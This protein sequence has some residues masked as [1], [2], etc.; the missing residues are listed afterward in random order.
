MAP[1][2]P[3]AGSSIIGNS[4]NAGTGGSGNSVESQGNSGNTGNQSPG[5]RSIAPEEVRDHEYL[6]KFENAGDF[7]KD[8]IEARSKMPGSKPK[9]GATAE[10]LIAWRK[11]RGLPEKPEG[12][13]VSTK[14]GDGTELG[15]DVRKDLQKFFHDNDMTSDTAKAVTTKLIGMIGKGSA[16]YP[17]LVDGIKIEVR[18][19]L[20]G[21]AD[22]ERDAGVLALNKEWGDKYK[23]NV[24][25]ADR[26]L[27]KL[28]SKEDITEMVKD[29]I[30]RNPKLI[31]TFASAFNLISEDSLIG[32]HLPGADMKSKKFPNSPEMYE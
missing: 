32:G 11:E 23:E 30:F 22:A 27:Q 13:E 21:E 14:L 3:G 15:E 19:A 31:K 17:Q 5:W 29:G 4:G 20:K 2:D 28:A 10:E 26:V 24:E 1:D 7:F 12:Y 8:V 9:E 18:A 16:A 25:K 6:Q